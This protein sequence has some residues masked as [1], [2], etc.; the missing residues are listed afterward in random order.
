MQD[1]FLAAAERALGSSASPPITAPIATPNEPSSFANG[2][3]QVQKFLGEGG[4]KKVYLAHDTTL[5]REVAFSLIKS[6]GEASGGEVLVSALLKELTESAG[7]MQFGE[8]REVAL[9]GLEGMNRIYP[10]AW[11]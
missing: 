11:E 2:R 5:D 7:D 3:Y 8:A 6:G 9:K 10:V 1:C 4:K